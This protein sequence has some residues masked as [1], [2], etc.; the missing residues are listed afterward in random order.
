MSKGNPFMGQ[1]RGKVGDVVMARVKGQQTT[2]AYNG[3]PN[4]PKSSAQ[5]LQRS[6]FASMVKMYKQGRQAFFQFAFEDKAI[7]ESDYNAFMRH[8]A[9]RG[10]ATS[11]A[12]L[13][14]N[15]YPVLVPAVMTAGSLPE[16]VTE[17]NAEG[18]TF[19]AVIA[20]VT[21]SSTFGGL[22]QALVNNYGFLQGDII[23]IC[24]IEAKGSTAANTPAVE[25]EKRG[26]V[27]WTIRQ[28]VLDVDSTDTIAS[29]LGAEVAAAAG[30]LAITPGTVGTNATAVCLT[31]SRNT[32]DGLKV[33]NTILC[34]DTIAQTILTAEQADGY[35]G[36]VL[37]SWKATGRAIL[38]GSLVQ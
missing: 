23:T 5:M 16:I 8:N 21:T 31:M 18:S 20:G 34:L 10:V 4:N 11:Q 36:D 3:K 15:S 2:R 1:M 35:I 19:D 22:S 37:A 30:A 7:T 9:K 33:S 13:Q 29:K 17:Y 32:V 14:E 26:N 12:A 6:I 25:P 24:I 28:A 38:Q 27:Q